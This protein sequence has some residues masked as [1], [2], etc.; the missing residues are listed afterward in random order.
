M[1]CKTRRNQVRGLVAAGILVVSLA[2]C[3]SITTTSVAD[4]LATY[5]S[6]L[7]AQVQSP[8]II[9]DG[10]L[11]VGVIQT[12]SAPLSVVDDGEL[13]GIDADMAAL[14][15]D[16]LGLKV[17]FVS[18]DNVSDSLGKTCDV[19]MGISSTNDD[20]VTVVGSYAERA[21]AF[22]HKGD[23]GTVSM[24]DLNGKKVAV[25]SGSRAAAQLSASNLSV[26]EDD[27]PG[28]DAAF[29][30][31]DQG[32][33]DYVLCS[34]YTGAYLAQNYD[35]INICGTIDAPLPIGVAVASTNTNLQKNVEQALSTISSSGLEDIVRS[36]WVGSLADLTDQTQVE[37]VTT[38]ASASS[39]GSDED[40]DED[41]S[42]SSSTTSSSSSY[43]TSDSDSD[44][45]SAGLSA[46]NPGD[47][48]TA[49][50]NAV[51]TAVG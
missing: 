29:D 11:T 44:D 46:D 37:G 31:L 23:A 17:K 51:S 33:V 13:K 35:G 19:V 39:K 41:G 47:G 50:A 21:S 15:A 1:S 38:S 16:Q 18:I 34:A 12:S 49:G 3:G 8:T 32:E 24:S 48:S 27:Y 6:N 43:G 2:G 4:S 7:S 10:T 30:A 14:L 25:Q 9:Q 26:D 36:R 42:D 20:D 40:E 45:D 22:F 5:S 28:I